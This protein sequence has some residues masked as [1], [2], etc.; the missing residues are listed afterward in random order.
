MLAISDPVGKS[1]K[2]E[3]FIGGGGI[4]FIY[5]YK[6]SSKKDEYVA[7]NIPV[8]ANGAYNFLTTTTMYFGGSISMS[9]K[10][11]VASMPALGGMPTIYKALSTGA[12]G[13]GCFTLYDI[14]TGRELTNGGFSPYA[15]SDNKYGF[16]QSVAIEGNTIV[17]S[18]VTES[19]GGFRQYEFKINDAGSADIKETI[20]FKPS[21]LG[22]HYLGNPSRGLFIAGSVTGIMGYCC[23]RQA[24][25]AVDTSVG[26]T[27]IDESKDLLQIDFQPSND[28]YQLRSAGITYV[29]KTCYL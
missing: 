1:Q 15:K 22:G 21:A 13:Y 6:W 20:Q 10:Y 12:T 28:F 11:L 4:G 19:S 27:T 23:A 3:T 8:I 29:N 7:H 26:S 25:Y 14:E 24:V 2:S 18:D 5:L 17:V 16:S 9:G